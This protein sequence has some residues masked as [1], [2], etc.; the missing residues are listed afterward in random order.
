MKP[1]IALTAIFTAS[2]MANAFTYAP[3]IF[4][5][6]TSVRLAIHAP[7]SDLT[8]P[9]TLARNERLAENVAADTSAQFNEMTVK[10]FGR[11]LPVKAPRAVR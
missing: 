11:V 6:T 3:G 7:T 10:N 1:A 5:P 4:Q 2:V 8:D 9:T